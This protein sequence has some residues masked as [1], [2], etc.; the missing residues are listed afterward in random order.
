MVKKME[1]DGRNH[2]ERVESVELGSFLFSKYWTQ[3]DTLDAVRA[4][5]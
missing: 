2:E 4:R 3:S 5:I 1:R